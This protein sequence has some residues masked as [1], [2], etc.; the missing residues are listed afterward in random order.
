[1]QPMALKIRAG[2]RDLMQSTGMTL[3]VLYGRPQ[4]EKASEG[5]YA[6]FLTIYGGDFNASYAISSV[7]WRM[8]VIDSSA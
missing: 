5:E 4:A 1:M 2:G 7:S 8:Q 6:A 3:G